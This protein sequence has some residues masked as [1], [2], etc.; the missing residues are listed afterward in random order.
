MGRPRSSKRGTATTGRTFAAPYALDDA[1]EKRVLDSIRKGNFREVAAASAGISRSTFYNWVAAGR[2]QKSGRLFDFVAKL[3][4][5]EAEA[6]ERLVGRIDSAAEKDWRAD[7][8]RLERK[9]PERWARRAVAGE[10]TTDP[11]LLKL[12]REKLEL[13][14]ALA[15]RKLEEGG[16]DDDDA[17]PLDPESEAFRAYLREAHGFERAGLKEKPG[18]AEAANGTG[19]YKA[20]H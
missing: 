6:E 4:Q 13:E 2:R 8:W 19:G 1:T 3:E 20:R 9:V 16:G 12:Q 5:A 11:K 7:A 10:E 15:R 17:G 18:D 14:N